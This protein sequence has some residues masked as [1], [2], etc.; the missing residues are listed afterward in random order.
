M[1]LE[2]G[3]L[4]KHELTPDEYVWLY[5]RYFQDNTHVYVRI[6]TDDLKEREWLNED[7]SL[8]PKSCSLFSDDISTWIEEWREVFPNIRAS[9]GNVRGDRQG[10]LKK[11]KVFCKKYPEYTK[12]II[13]KG[14]QNYVQAKKRDGY[15]FMKLAH[16]FIE[17]DG[18]S[19][20]ASY[21][22]QVD[23]TDTQND[24]RISVV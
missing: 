24:E 15:Q 2:L 14:T 8:S 16:Y 17:K 6:S 11:M 12:E 13:F 21:C 9:H 5:K 3:V 19:D 4:N 7:L 23:N 1:N 22:E 18:I 10:C 20:L